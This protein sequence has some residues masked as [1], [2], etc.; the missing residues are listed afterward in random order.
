C[1][2]DNR[3]HQPREHD[4]APE[5]EEIVEALPQGNAQVLVADL[6]DRDSTGSVRCAAA[7][8]RFSRHDTSFNGAV[9]RNWRRA[10]ALLIAQYGRVGQRFTQIAICGQCAEEQHE[11]TARLELPEPALLR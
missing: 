5:G 10:P 3:V 7:S 2:S 4:V 1:N 8:D 11:Q 9:R 6:A